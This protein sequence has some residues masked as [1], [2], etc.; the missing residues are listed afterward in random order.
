MRGAVPLK[1]ISN[2]YKIPDHRYVWSPSYMPSL[3]NNL[4]LKCAFKESYSGTGQSGP[5][6]VTGTLI[7]DSGRNNISLPSEP[8]PW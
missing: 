4:M 1:I 3:A 6:R 2:D 7:K 5:D 8:T